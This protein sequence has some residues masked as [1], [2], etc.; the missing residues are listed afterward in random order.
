MPWWTGRTLD[1]IRVER[2]NEPQGGRGGSGNATT[3]TTRRLALLQW[4]QEHSVPLAELYQGAMELTEKRT[5]GWT[6]FVSHAVR[7]ISNRLPDVVAEGGGGGH[8]IDKNRLDAFCD[9]WRQYGLPIDGSTPT[10]DVPLGASQV[11]PAQVDVVGKAV[12]PAAVF[13]AMAAIVRDHES[14]RERPLEKAMRM[15]RALMPEGTDHATRPSLEQWVELTRSAVG[16]THNQTQKDADLADRT[17]R[18]FLLF[19]DTLLGLVLPYF[20]TVKEI[21]ALLDKANS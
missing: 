10:L 15:R 12:V 6:K 2:H 17:M 14:T 7:E 20:E 18:V 21:D 1:S 3:R 8:L 4:L 13:E 19:E 16:L 11:S 5:A 9:Q